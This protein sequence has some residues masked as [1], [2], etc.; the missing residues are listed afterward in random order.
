MTDEIDHIVTHS[1]MYEKP[2]L[3]TYGRID[4]LTEDVDDGYGPG[5]PP[6]SS[7]GDG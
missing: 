3:E 5:A 6:P 2:W 7:G 1:P 4:D